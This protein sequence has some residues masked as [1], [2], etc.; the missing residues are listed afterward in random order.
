MLQFPYVDE[1]KTLLSKGLIHLGSLLWARQQNS[2]LTSESIEA[3]HS[4]KDYRY[5]YITYHCTSI[6]FIKAAYIQYDM[7]TVDFD[8]AFFASIDAA[9]HNRMSHP[10]MGIIILQM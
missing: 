9:Y 3:I 10:P 1:L 7:G 5:T 8:V 6:S 4:G 2:L